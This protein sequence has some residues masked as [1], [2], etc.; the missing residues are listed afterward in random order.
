MAEQWVYRRFYA[1][2]YVRVHNAIQRCTNEDNPQYSDY[3]G[4]GI[5]V[6]APWLD[7]PAQFMAYLMTLPGWDDPSL[8]LDRRDKSGNYEPGN[9][10]FVSK[11]ISTVEG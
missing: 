6:Y 7:D 9:L 10:R 2:T 8:V 4:R 1:R 11:V 3:G 5:G